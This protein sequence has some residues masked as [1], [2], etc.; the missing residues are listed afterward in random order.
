MG[1]K[2]FQ[3]LKREVIDAGLCNLCGACLGVCSATGVN[4]LS[5]QNNQPQITGDPEIQ[6]KCLE[7]GLCYLICGQNP[8]LD[9]KLQSL[10]AA[11]P[12]IGTYKFLAVARSID[13]EIRE[14]AQDGG[15]VTS[16]LKYLFEKNL[17]DGAVVN[18]T[19]GEW[20]SVPALITSVE[21]LMN[22]SGT[23]YTAVP[24]VQELGN[25]GSIEMDNPRLAFVGTPCQVQTIRK[26]QVLNARPGIFVQY[27]I[28]L[29][30]MENF[31]YETLM[32][33]KIQNELKVS[34]EDIRKVNIKK[35][36]FV[37]LKDGKQ[38]EIPLEDL[39]KLVR[40]NCHYCIDF[41]N[42]FADISVGGIGSP[43]GYST[44][45]IRTDVGNTLF[46]KA[47]LE[48]HIEEAE[49]ESG[50]LLQ[51]KT[52]ILTQIARLGHMKHDRGTKNKQKL[53]GIGGS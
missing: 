38:I 1:I 3:D 29:F 2:V 10:C 33:E 30:C 48:N 15:I 52:K 22:T 13:P 6:T 20:K 11:D 51:I 32:K 7:C 23:R 25:Y 26:M 36:F 9:S 41:T 17:I 4:A 19:I 37:T 40:K 16:L 34:L 5:I 47:L 21:Q 50:D 43:S 24:A 12:P 45:L 27:L 46:S 18:R 39:N 8:N 53:K 14:K 31:D 42:V 35:N 44:V 49:G 28:G